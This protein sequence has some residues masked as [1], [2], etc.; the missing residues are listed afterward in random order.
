RF[1]DIQPS[2][3]AIVRSINWQLLDIDPLSKGNMKNYVE[4]L[5]IL[6]AI[7]LS[8]CP[9]MSSRVTEVLWKPPSLHWVK[10]NTDDASYGS[11]GLAGTGSIFRD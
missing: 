5:C 8:G 9:A 1:Y 3:T 2:I 10:V 11:P 4:E 6:H 7:G